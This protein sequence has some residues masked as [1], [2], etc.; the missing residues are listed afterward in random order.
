MR[1][2][3]IFLLII[4][5]A[6]F[7]AYMT[8]YEKNYFVNT[9]AMPETYVLPGGDLIGLKVYSKGVIIIGETKVQSNDGKWYQGY[10]KGSFRAGDIIIKIDNYNIEEAQ[11]INTIINK[12][13][14]E[15]IK[16]TI[17]RNGV[18]YIK[19]IRPIKSFEDGKYK[20]GLWVRDGAKGV[21]TLSFY[22]P[23]QKSFVALGHGISDEDS[24]KIIELDNGEVFK[25]TAVAITKGRKDY[26]GE[27]KGYLN[28]NT[29][30]GEITQNI[31]SGIYGKISSV[32]S[33]I[34]S[35]EK[36]LV[37]SKNETKIGEAK[38]ICTA[39]KENKREEFNV[40]VQKILSADILKQKGMIIKITDENLLSKTGGIVQGMSG[41]PVIQ[42]NKLIGVITHVYLNDPTKGYAIF[43]EEIIKNI[44]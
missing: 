40:E 30:I 32:S 19:Y 9:N 6:I 33:D 12:I 4:V 37:A 41:S 20:L 36:I 13:G 35:R 18:Q 25:A 7:F 10:E 1:Q 43:A 14:D 31:E 27:I 16:I 15:E 5:F 11:E 38:I 42:N 3:K 8:N 17:L 44:K 29:K 21:G 26:P 22:M 28:E 23:Q 39:G 24:K 34:L 2:K